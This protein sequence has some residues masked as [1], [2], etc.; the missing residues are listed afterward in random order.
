A[1][2][3]GR[4][5]RTGGGLCFGHRAQGAEG[6]RD[7]VSVRLRGRD[8][9]RAAGRRSG[10]GDHGPAPR[11]PRAR[12]RRPGALP[13]GDGRPDRRDRHRRP[14]HHRRAF[15]GRDHLVGD[16]RPDRDGF[17]R[18]GGGHGGRA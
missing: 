2:G 10:R 9:A 14:D 7:R 18:R 3:A 16:P 12:D 11:R 17:L 15:A 1:D 5:D 13:D 8:R 4:G 6:R